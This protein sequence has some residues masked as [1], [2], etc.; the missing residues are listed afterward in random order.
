[1]VT[2]REFFTA[3]RQLEIDRAAPVIVHT[4]LSAFGKVHGGAD[5]VLGAL[6]GA[7]NTVLMPT[8]TYKT[9]VIPEVGPPE[10]ALRYGSGVAVNRMSEF[11]SPDMPADKLMGIVPETLRRRPGVLRSGHPILSFAGV[12]A[13]AALNAQ[14][15][16]EPLAPIHALALDNGWV[17]MMGVNHTANTSIHYAERMVGRK[18]FTRWALTP[19]GVIECPGFPGCSDGF[20]ALAPHVAEIARSVLVGQALVTAVP[21]QGLV[22]V[23]GKLINADPLVLL[24]G[25]AECERCNAVRASV[26]VKE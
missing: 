23:V 19:A 20:Q 22:E 2:F 18:Q 9:M 4:S 14:T 12:N 13:N 6:M 5:T 10:N 25:R 17:L 16:D 7:F 21:I 1:M 3:L 15:L 8:F 11:F 26:V 24:C